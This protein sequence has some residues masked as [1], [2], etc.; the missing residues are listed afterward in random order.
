MYKQHILHYNDQLLYHIVFSISNMHVHVHV[1]CVH[2]T[3]C[4]CA[5]YYQH[6][7]NRINFIKKNDTSFLCPGHFKQFS[8]HSGTLQFW[9]KSNIKIQEAMKKVAS[10]SGKHPCATTVHV[11]GNTLCTVCIF[12]ASPHP[13]IVLQKSTHVHCTCTCTLYAH[14][15]FEL[16]K[17]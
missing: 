12:H 16:P 4:T 14:H 3:T 10:R 9:W 1:F 6:T 11:I 8:H 17:K 15:C 7:S 13:L 5:L 2:W